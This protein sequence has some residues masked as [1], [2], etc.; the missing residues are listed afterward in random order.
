MNLNKRVLGIELNHILSLPI[1]QRSTNRT[2]DLRNNSF[3]HLNFQEFARTYTGAGT[4]KK[5]P[6]QN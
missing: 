5:K 2:F 1:P 6:K 3:S 4:F